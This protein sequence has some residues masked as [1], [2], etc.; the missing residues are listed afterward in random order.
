M[1]LDRIVSVL[2]LFFVAWHFWVFG[3]E[4]RLDYRGCPE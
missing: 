2:T 3:K 1:D 4:R